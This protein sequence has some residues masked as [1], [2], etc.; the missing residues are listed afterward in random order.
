MHDLAKQEQLESFWGDY[1][2]TKQHIFHM[3][4]LYSRIQVYTTDK[5]F[6]YLGLH[7]LQWIV[8]SASGSLQH[9][10]SCKRGNTFS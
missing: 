6:S 3:D 5:F 10:Q 8:A 1:L 9:E 4:V 2:I 7:S